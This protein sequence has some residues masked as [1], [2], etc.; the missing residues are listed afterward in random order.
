MA[1]IF[2]YMIAEPAQ[3][4]D[5][6]EDD[7][8]NG[9]ASITN[10][11]N[12]LITSVIMKNRIITTAFILFLAFWTKA[13]EEWPVL[14]TYDQEHIRKIALPIGGIGTGTVSLSGRG[15]RPA[16]W[17]L[18]TNISR[19]GWPRCGETDIMEF[20]G[21][22]SLKVYS[23][24]HWADTT[25]GK[26]RSAGK[27][28]SVEPPPSA[29][30]HVYAIDWT[31]QTIYFYYDDRKYFSFETDQAGTGTDKPFRKPFYLIL[32]LA[33]GG[34][35]GTIDDTALPQQ[36]LVDYVRMYESKR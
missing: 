25:T 16:I 15:T 31:P 18:G 4:G 34:W 30:F 11:P 32:N 7:N 19:V 10:S 6:Y 5:K 23:T 22:D 13:Q 1:G 17:L 26:H 28:I 35:G 33:L 12:G 8:G 24:C 36:F 20:P 3:G 27:H 14:K 9:P 2:P 29:D 21:R